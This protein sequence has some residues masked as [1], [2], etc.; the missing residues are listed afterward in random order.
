MPCQ[1]FTP[2]LTFY[3]IPLLCRVNALSGI[4][5]LPAYLSTSLLEP[6]HRLYSIFAL[7]TNV[8]YSI[9]MDPAKVE[10]IQEWET[11]RTVKDVQAF[12]GFANFYRQFIFKYS[13][14]AALLTAITRNGPNGKPVF[15]WTP[16][17]DEAFQALKHAFTTNPILAHFEPGLKTMIETDASDSVVACVASQEHVVNGRKVWR[18]VAY[19][20][21]KMSPAERNYDIYDKELLAIVKAFDEYRPELTMSK[22]EEP[23][24]VVCDH[25][26]LEYF[27]TTKRLNSRQAQALIKPIRTIPQSPCRH[28]NSSHD[29]LEKL[30]LEGAKIL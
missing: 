12:L 10:A 26:N 8:L 15:S 29:P 25:K 4:H 5:D 30:E 18:P 3:V 16:E 21:K 22:D 7:S 13:K 23:V 28:K 27:M 6:L 24:K 14:L 19:F 17:A 20:S 9:C 1:A 2:S 11:L